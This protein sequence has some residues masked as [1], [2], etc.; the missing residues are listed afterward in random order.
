MAT[1]PYSKDEMLNELRVIFLFEADHIAMGKGQAAAAAF[2]GFSSDQYYS[3]DPSKVD[4]AEFE[5]SKAF[6]AAFDF[7]FQVGAHHRFNAAD[8]QDLIVFLEGTPRIGGQASEGGETHPFMHPQGFCRR[9]VDTAQARWWLDHPEE[10]GEF[11]VRHLALL[12]NMTEGAVRNALAAEK[13][14]ATGKRNTVSAEFAAEWLRGRRGFVPTRSPVWDE[15][16]LKSDLRNARSPHDLGG[17]IRRKLDAM[18]LT[19]E[20]VA[21]RLR[22]PLKDV[23]R[24][25]RGHVDVDVSKATAFAEALAFETNVFAG[26]VVEIGL[27][28]KHSSASNCGAHA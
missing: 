17:V 4:L 7:A 28:M 16:A 5:I 2:V 21:E 27:G 3:E 24:W 10:A 25:C 14:K 18:G 19:E 23:S 1:L 15:H 22:W 9:T 26:R 6:D 11:T 20:A 13:V 12:A 8:L